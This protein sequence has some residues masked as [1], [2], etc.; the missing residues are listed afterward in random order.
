MIAASTVV[1]AARRKRCGRCGAPGS[2][3]GATSSVSCWL[4]T[5]ERKHDEQTQPPDDEEDRDRWEKAHFSA[6]SSSISVPPK[7][8]GLRKITGRPCAPIIGS[9]SAEDCGAPSFEAVARFADVVDLVAEVM[10]SP[11]GIAGEESGDGR[12]VAERLHQFDVRIRQLDEHDADAVLGQA[13]RPRHLRAELV[14]IEPRR[15]FQIGNRERNMVQPAKHGSVAK[16]RV[17]RSQSLT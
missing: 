17:L 2:V 4:F 6:S 3:P 12:V 9:P 7:S 5:P 14:A 1:A 10:H 8:F 15:G 11:G 16:D 13:L